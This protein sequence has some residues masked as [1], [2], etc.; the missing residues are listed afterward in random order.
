MTSGEPW[1]AV[2]QTVLRSKSWQPRR[3][4]RFSSH[5]EAVYWYIR[6]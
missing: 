2:A 1:Q 4:V 3:G 6:L 5:G